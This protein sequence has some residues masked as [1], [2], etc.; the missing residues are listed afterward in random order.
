MKT[1]S[2]QRNDLITEDLILSIRDYL[3][4][5]PY[6]EIKDLMPKLDIHMKDKDKL[7]ILSFIL[8]KEIGTQVYHVMF[9]SIDLS[10]EGNH[11]IIE[12]PIIKKITEYISDYP[13]KEIINLLPKLDT[14]MTVEDKLYVINYLTSKN[15]VVFC[16]HIL[17]N[18]VDFKSLKEEREAL[19]KNE[20]TLKTSIGYLK[21]SNQPII[22][23]PY[24][25]NEVIDLPMPNLK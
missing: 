20:E 8:T 4:G 2:V 12:E 6:K 19:T 1:A 13:Y 15:R 23:E 16:Y 5:F 10:G 24:D 22:D 14:K 25:I 17:F 9:D 3:E 11:K 7:E 21:P 18:S